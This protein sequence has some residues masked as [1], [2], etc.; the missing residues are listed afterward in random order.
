[1]SSSISWTWQANSI[2][3]STDNL[4]S[5]YG[6][7]YG[8]PIKIGEFQKSTHIRKSWTE[9]TQLDT[10]GNAMYNYSYV[11]DTEVSA[12][13]SYPIVLSGNSPTPGR[14]IKITLQ[15]AGNSW[16]FKVLGVKIFA[17]SGGDMTVPVSGAELYFFEVGQDRWHRLYGS[18]NAAVL[19]PRLTPATKHTWEIGISIKP[20]EIINKTATIRL[21]ADIQ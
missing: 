13:G 18:T 17:F 4:I 7:N 2:V 21:E 16:A 20:T 1:M 6:A 11:S 8:D 9:D 5:F 3:M 12:N 14:G 15:D 19:T 10:G